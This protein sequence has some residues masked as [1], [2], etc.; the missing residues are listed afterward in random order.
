MCPV[1]YCFDQLTI[2]DNHKTTQ[3][4]AVVRQPGQKLF[5]AKS[6]TL[7]AQ[8]AQCVLAWEVRSHVSWTL[9]HLFE[10]LGAGGRPGETAF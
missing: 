1:Q 10:L 6:M 9:E 8:E 7:A 2:Y 5:P 3:F 4:Y